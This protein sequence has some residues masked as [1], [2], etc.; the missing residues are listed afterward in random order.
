MATAIIHTTEEVI[1]IIEIK[2]WLKI[3]V[4]QNE[5]D[6]LLEILIQAAREG[7]EKYTGRG[8]ATRTITSDLTG[9]IDLLPNCPIIEILEVK[10]KDGNLLAE[11]DY[12]AHTLVIAGKDQCKIETAIGLY[13]LTVKFKGGYTAQTI[14]GEVKLAIYAAVAGFY[15]NRDEETDLT[16]GIKARLASYRLLTWF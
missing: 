8:F 16:P 6:G 4:G 12:T 1:T 10:D 13:P 2:N 3:P 7:A 11:G 14:P 15:R 5:E 9:P